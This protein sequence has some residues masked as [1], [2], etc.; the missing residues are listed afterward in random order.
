MDSDENGCAAAALII[1]SALKKE[2][3]TTWNL[4]HFSC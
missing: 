3:K 1:A 4:C 2:T